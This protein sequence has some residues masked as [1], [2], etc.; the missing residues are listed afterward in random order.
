MHKLLL[1]LIMALGLSVT[2]AQAAEF[3]SKDEA[4][5]LTK[6]AI[7]LVDQ[8]GFDKA[9]DTLM[10]PKGKFVDRDLYIIV[11]DIKSGSRI[12]HGQNPKLVGTSYAD[13]TDVN[14]KA[15]G[16]EAMDMLASKSS[17]WV[18]YSFT[19]PVSKKILP[20]EAYLERKGDYAFI[21]G[22]YKR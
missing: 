17:G 15:Y 6:T 7:A 1:A 5:K 2:G 20:K 11:V 3:G 14:G 13:A 16:K 10:D 4:V 21:C 18:E 9:K 19:D 8:D 12:A 22:V